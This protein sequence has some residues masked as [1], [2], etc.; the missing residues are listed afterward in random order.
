MVWFK[1]VLN[2]QQRYRDWQHQRLLKKYNL[3][4]R[5]YDRLYDPDYNI[6]GRRL[7]RDMYHGYSYVHVMTRVP[8]SFQEWKY[9]F[10]V[11]EMAKWCEENCQGKWRNDW[12][13]I[14][15]DVWEEG[16]WEENGISGLD[17]MCF[18]FKDS[19]DFTI[20]CL[21]WAG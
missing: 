10:L 6:R 15:E 13:R 19:R 1:M 3:T 11:D 18:A 12:H 2:L 7:K 17:A 21:R 9:H 4:Q 16:E 8:D 14:I 5:Q 20:F